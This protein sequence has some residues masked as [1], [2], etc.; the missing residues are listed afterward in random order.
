MAR[1]RTD[2]RVGPARDED[3]RV[4]CLARQ[5]AD[6]S[7]LVRVPALQTERGAVSDRSAGGTEGEAARWKMRERVPSIT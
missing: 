3:V 5:D 1:C 6:E 7:L 4:C 2:E